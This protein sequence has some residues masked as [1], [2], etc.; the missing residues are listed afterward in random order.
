VVPNAVL[1]DQDPVITCLTSHLLCERTRML[2]IPAPAKINLHLEILGRR[3]DGFHGL[4]TVFQT[5]AL[6]DTVT[7]GVEPGAGIALAC[8]DPSLPADA[9][10]LAWRA[11]AAV[12]LR[13]PQMGRIVITLDKR[14]PH[15]AGLGGG[16]SDAASV[17]LAL[18]EQLDEPLASLELAEI[19]LDLGSDVPFF[20]IGGTAHA[21]GR[22]EELT[23]LTALPPTPVTV[24]MPTAQLPTPAVFKEL[25]AAERGPR[26]ARGAGWAAAQ[27][28]A[29]LLHNRLTGPARRL[30]PE[31]AALLDWLALQGV[32]HLLSG[33][34]AACFALARVSAP[35][36]VRA[37][38]TSTAPGA[39]EYLP[40]RKGCRRFD[41]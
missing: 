39:P 41:G 24:L 29:A 7:V 28:L 33:S 16:S 36:G 25:N 32:P 27:P 12:Q 37:F 10:N 18:N 5:L 40:H 31:V 23:P 35:T 6:A 14:I 30:C 17:L 38:H 13:R 15:G 1:A 19:A 8:S 2:T 3:E 20:L 34:G 22:G 4:E 11:A 9:R 21:T 26:A